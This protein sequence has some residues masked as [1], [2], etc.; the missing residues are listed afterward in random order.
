MQNLFIS[1]AVSTLFVISQN[2]QS[3][4]FTVV[5]TNNSGA[6]SFADAVSLANSDNTTPRIINFNILG[7]GV[8]TN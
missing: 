3:A 8:K 4:T 7:T 5:N 6:G 2:A 1:I